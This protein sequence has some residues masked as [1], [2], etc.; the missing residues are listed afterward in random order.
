[1]KKFF[2]ISLALII[3]AAGG[4]FAYQYLVKNAANK[5]AN[6]KSLSTYTEPFQWG[7]TMGPSDLNRYSAEIWRKQIKVATN[8]GVGWIRLR[9]DSENPDP[10]QRNDDEIKNLEDY[11]LQTVLIIE[12]DPRKDS[13]KID[14]YKDGYNDGFTIAS[15][16]KGRIKFY[17]MANEGG[18]QTIKEPT[19]NGQTEDQFDEAKY[20]PLRDYIKGLSEGIAKADP[21]AWRIV[22]SAYTH[23]GYLDKLIKDKIDFDMV[24]IDWYDWMGP[25]N[26]K[27]LENGQMLVDKLKSYNKPLTF[28]EVNAI[29]EGKTKKSK[30]KTVVDENRQSDIISKTAKWAWENKDYVKGFF[31][32]SLFDGVNNPNENVEYFGIVEAKQ[33]SSGVN[34]PG[35]PRQSFYT[36][37]DLIKKYSGQ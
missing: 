17:Q 15:H 36:Y 4:Y 35:E 5:K 22:S 18:A 30:S 11:K 9:Y 28:M 23:V 21:S 7:V 1:M 31:V 6:V 33:S 16:Y 27:K 8:L 26:E 34:V 29:P 37:Q 13:A 19:M 20:K 12:Q 32:L 10:F 14:N 25:I 24:G 3:G 2:I